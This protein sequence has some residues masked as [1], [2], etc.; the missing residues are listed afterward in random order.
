MLARPT[1]APELS[2]KAA[3]GVD[4][5]RRA[6]C[7]RRRGARRCAPRR[8]RG[9]GVMPWRIAFSTSVTSI[10]GGNGSGASV[11]S[12]TSVRTVSRAPMRILLHLRGTRARARAR[13]R[14]WSRAE[15]MRGSIALRYCDR[16]SSIAVRGGGV[17]LEQPA[18]VGERVEQEVRL[19][20]RLHHQERAL[21]RARGRGPSR[22]MLLVVQPRDGL[23]L[24]GQEEVAERRRRRSRGSTARSP[25]ISLS[26]VAGSSFCAG[27]SSA[28][29]PPAISVAERRARSSRRPSSVSDP[30]P[31]ARRRPVAGDDHGDDTRRRTTR[32]MLRSATRT[33]CAT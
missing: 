4:D 6:A 26:S 13:G 8:P 20:L 16:C 27:K 19:D 1:P 2:D 21:R 15:R 17:G 30:G 12:G 3:A 31:G 9:S 23:L 7:R 22:R 28:S 25:Q 18:H 14:A 10:I 24:A 29:T 5:L 33:T 32:S 11:A